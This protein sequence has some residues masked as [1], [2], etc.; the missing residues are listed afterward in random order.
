MIQNFY[1]FSK[2]W[3]TAWTCKALLKIELSKNSVWKKK[4]LCRSMAHVLIYTKKY[5]MIYLLIKYLINSTMTFLQ[6]M[7][8]G[9][10]KVFVSGFNKYYN[11]NLLFQKPLL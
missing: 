11:T 8:K 9:H 4:T 10:I 1:K 7:L 3:W 5:L 2:D 6:Q